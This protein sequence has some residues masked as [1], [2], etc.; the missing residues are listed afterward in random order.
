MLIS[1]KVDFTTRN[2]IDRERHYVMTKGSNHQENIAILNACALNKRA[3]KYICNNRQNRK[4]K[5]TN[6]QLLLRDFNIFLFFSLNKWQNQIE[7]FQDEEKINIFKQEDLKAIYRTIYRA[8]AKCT[9]FSSAYRT[10]TK[11]GHVVCDKTNL[12]KC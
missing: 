12:N 8:M 7:N 1:D 3:A 5:G 10:Y 6:Q 4:E 2:N 11:I 9:F